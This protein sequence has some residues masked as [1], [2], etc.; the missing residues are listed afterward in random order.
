MLESG[1]RAPQD[2]SLAD[3]GAARIE[4][5]RR[6]SPVLDGMVRRTLG[7][8]SLRGRRVAVV[9]HLEA[10]TA[11][12]ATVLADAGADVIVAGSNPRTTEA[13]VVAA[14][15]ARG[16]TVVSDAGGNHE[17]WERELR[18]AA[19]L[20]PEYIVD[21]GAE[22]TTRTLEHRPDIF[23]RLKGVSEETT[24]GTARLKA[25][26]ATGQLPFAALTANDARCKHLFDNRYA[27][28]QTTIQALLRLT[29][30]QIAGAR[31]AV[32]GY[33]FVGKGVA[34]YAR[35]LGA[36]TFVTEID[37]VRAL[38]AHTDGHTVGRR[39]DV[40]PHAE[41]VVTTT[42]G[43]RAIGDQDLPLLASDAVLAN[44]GHHD[45]EVDTEALS[46]AASSV[47][48]TRPGITTYRIDD[49]DIHVLVGGALA[50]IAGGA[51]HPVEVMDLSFAVQGLGVHHLATTVL[52]PGVHK[53]PRELDDSIAMARLAS[54]GIGIDQLRDDQLDDTTARFMGGES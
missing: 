49:R 21:D 4:W 50:N 42:G 38:E 32:V 6:H 5:A 9:V 27:T 10:K 46:R 13:S 40:L 30:R 7:D 19:D 45:L 41:F 22:L 33:G 15:R 47:D 48:R 18:A 28:G 12:L 26:H 44:A 23:A 11:F 51:G 35:A 31:I 39:E 43:M 34:L 16:M 2:G 3:E 20:E 52:E 17:S 8:G 53:I 37:P 1:I 24:T 14:L 36:R 25:M 54:M 29:N